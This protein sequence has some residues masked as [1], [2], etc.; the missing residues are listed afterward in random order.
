MKIDAAERAL[1]ELASVLDRPFAPASDAESVVM[2]LAHR[3]RTLYRGYLTC[4]K[5]GLSPL[6][7]RTLLRPMVETNILLRFIR[8]DPDLHAR[9]WHAESRRVWL[10]PIE[11]IRTRPSRRVVA[12]F[13]IDFWKLFWGQFSELLEADLAS[14]ERFERVEKKIRS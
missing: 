7:G 8:E 14:R 4:T 11:Q 3:S 2:A 6:A 9:L 13:E 5:A 12:F 1:L 10:G